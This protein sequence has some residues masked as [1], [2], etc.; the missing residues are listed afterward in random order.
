MSID[1]SEIGDWYK[2]YAERH[3]VHWCSVE[4]SEILKCFFFGLACE[5]N[6]GMII[7]RLKSSGRNIHK[8]AEVAK[9]PTAL[10]LRSGKVQDKRTSGASHLVSSNLT[11]SVILPVI[12]N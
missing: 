7:V 4:S 12:S 10:V 9:R 3:C 8:R 6:P 1:D 11:L 2:N 5:E